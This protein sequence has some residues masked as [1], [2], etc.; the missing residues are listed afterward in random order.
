MFFLLGKTINTLFVFSMKS[1]LNRLFSWKGSAFCFFTV[2]SLIFSSCKNSDGANDQQ[3]NEVES[4]SFAA[5]PL[6]R[7]NVFDSTLLNQLDTTYGAHLQ[8]SSENVRELS[9]HYSTPAAEQIYFYDAIHEYF[10]NDSLHQ[11]DSVQYDI[12][13]ILNSEAFVLGKKELSKGQLLIWGIKY[14]SYEACPYYTG[15]N[16]FAS[17]LLDNKI[18]NSTVIASNWAVADPPMAAR[19]P[20]SSEL[21]DTH[22]SIS[23]E[24]IELEIEETER[25]TSHI[26]STQQ[27]DYLKGVFY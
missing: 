25:I 9:S 17:Y 1:Y 23:Y 22:L 14:G 24:N 10:L 19:T 16:L 6:L 15:V 4:L 11:A 27:Y 7:E 8:L 26:K 21:K 20:F 2:G 13:M 5:W 18:R 3:Q 12:G